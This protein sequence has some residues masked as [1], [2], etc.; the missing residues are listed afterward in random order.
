MLEGRLVSILVRDLTEAY[1]Q[2]A[3]DISDRA[4]SRIEERVADQVHE[5]FEN[6]RGLNVSVAYRRLLRNPRILRGAGADIFSAWDLELL[7]QD[8]PTALTPFRFSDLP[9]LLYLKILLDGLPGETFDHIVVD[10]AQDITP[11]QF[12]L[13]TLFCPA[14]NMTV[15]GDMKQGIYA[16]H[17]V[18]DWDEL[19]GDAPFKLE[20]IA[21]SYRSTKQINTYANRLL[22]RVGFDG[23]QLI[24]SV[25][26]EGPEVVQSGF[27]RLDAWAQETLKVIQ[28]AARQNWKTTA[29]IGKTLA[30]CRRLEQAL[31]TAGLDAVKLIE[32]AGTDQ[33]APVIVIPLHLAKGLEFDVVVIADADEETY[34]TDALHA[35]LLYVAITRAA[36][37]LFVNWVG[38]LSLLLEDSNSL[39][40]PPQLFARVLEPTPLTIAEFAAKNESLDP[41]WCVERLAGAEKLHLLEQG[42]MDETVLATLLKSYRQSMQRTAERVIQPLE[43]SDRE[44]LT[45]M[46]RSLSM[47]PDTRTGLALTQLTYGLLRNHMRFAGLELD[48]ES[49]QNLE[50]QVILLRTFRQFQ[51]HEVG[52]LPMGRWTTERVV[53][54][55]VGPGRNEQALNA[56]NLLIDYGVVEKNKEQIRVNSALA[57][58][59]LDAGLG[60]EGLGWDSDLTAQLTLPPR[61]S[62]QDRRPGEVADVR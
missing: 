9:A 17:G 12:K 13:L 60:E 30:S 51:D 43:A 44:E 37:Q 39:V 36:H 62:I 33:I 53:L 4:R 20:R 24:D 41:V 32:D 2:R 34:P 29:I 49:E 48:S 61:L 26:R 31:K 47:D 7:A 46:V 57:L 52:E 42:R 22:S 59:L 14:K 18:S 40:E 1:T 56:L 16:H 50:E 19:I 25:S 55:L 27:G 45:T 11:M 21:N 5:Y 3:G 58:D 6:W 54:D 15:M 8:A 23:D 28:D 10:E 35:R 38:E